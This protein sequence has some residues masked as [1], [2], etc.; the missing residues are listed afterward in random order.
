[1]VCD[2]MMLPFPAHGFAWRAKV[3]DPCDYSAL[4]G[5]KVGLACSSFI[6]DNGETEK[7]ER[8]K[9]ERVERAT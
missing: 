3:F 4:I 7:K 6:H 9:R 2:T 1:M 8:E 5:T